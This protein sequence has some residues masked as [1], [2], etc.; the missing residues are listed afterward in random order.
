[1]NGVFTT[2]RP[3]IGFV[4]AT[5]TLAE[6]PLPAPLPLGASALGLLAFVAR[7]RKDAAKA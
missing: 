3:G 2:G 7:R 6:V 1:V 4:N 5:F